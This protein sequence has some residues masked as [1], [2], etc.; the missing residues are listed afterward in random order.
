MARWREQPGPAVV[1]AWVWENVGDPAVDM[2]LDDLWH[3]DRDWWD[4]AFIEIVSTPT[5][6]DGSRWRPDG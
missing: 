2:W 5:Y 4:R 1:P 6:A 3:R